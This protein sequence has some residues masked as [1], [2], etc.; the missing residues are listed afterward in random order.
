MTQTNLC[1]NKALDVFNLDIFHCNIC[2]QQINFQTDEFG[3]VGKSTFF[4]KKCADNYVIAERRTKT[5]D[6]CYVCKKWHPIENITVTKTEC[7]E[8]NTCMSCILPKMC[9][10]KRFVVM[11]E[12]DEDLC[13]ECIYERDGS[14]DEECEYCQCCGES[15]DCC[16]CCNDESDCDY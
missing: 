10:C 14:S 6:T 15:M 13:D 4:H 2:K 3:T 9:K 16:E 8:Y 1:I 5:H 11:E 12:K 7:R